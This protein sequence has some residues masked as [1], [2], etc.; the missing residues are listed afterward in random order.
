MIDTY[1]NS[2]VAGNLNLLVEITVQQELDVTS[3]FEFFSLTYEI[4][5]PDGIGLSKF[6]TGCMLNEPNEKRDGTNSVITDYT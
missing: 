2:A 4:A 3:E 6:E 5:A 1:E